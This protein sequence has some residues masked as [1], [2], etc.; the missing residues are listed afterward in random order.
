[1]KIRKPKMYC[2]IFFDEAGDKTLRLHKIAEI[3]TKHL[4]YHKGIAHNIT[5]Y[6]QD[7]TKT[8]QFSSQ[9]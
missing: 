4:K 7:R 6:T 8:D 9:K 1:M 3:F 5:E 2:L